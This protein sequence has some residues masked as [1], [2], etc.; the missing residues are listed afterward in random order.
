MHLEQ[1]KA[2]GQPFTL[3]LVDYQMPEMDGFEAGQTN[4]VRVFGQPYHDAD[5]R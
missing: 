5:V 2:Q 1:A 3:V 4:S